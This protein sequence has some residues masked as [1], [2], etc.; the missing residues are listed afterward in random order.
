[1]VEPLE[2]KRDLLQRIADGVPGSHFVSCAVGNDERAVS[3]RLSE[4]N[5]GIVTDG[6]PGQ[7]T[8]TVRC[9]RLQSI[10]EDLGSTVPELW[11]LDVQG[12]ELEVLR[13][14]DKLV[15]SAEMII[16]EISVLRIGDVPIFR[17]VDRYM[18]AVGFRLYDVIPQ[19]YR[20]LDGALWQ[21]DGFYVQKDSPLIA[22]RAWE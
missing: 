3:F 10:L 2:T 9:R 8:V 18:E 6:A 5:S 17:E 20:P 21:I 11:K 12:N 13:G 19:Y 22:S 4:T 1:M 7:D 14:A 16:L 15:S